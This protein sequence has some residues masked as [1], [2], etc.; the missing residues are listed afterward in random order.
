MEAMQQGPLPVLLVLLVLLVLPVL[1]VLLVLLVLRGS[2]VL[3]RG[4]LL[5]SWIEQS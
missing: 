3:P 1:R 5:Y 4:C 2:F